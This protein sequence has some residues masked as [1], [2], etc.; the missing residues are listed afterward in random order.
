[1]RSIRHRTSSQSNTQAASTPATAGR[2]RASQ[3]P[4]KANTKR[5]WPSDTE[6]TPLLKPTTPTGVYRLLKEPSPSCGNSHREIKSSRLQA[7]PCI[8]K[9]TQAASPGLHYS[10][11]SIA[12]PLQQEPHK[13]GSAAGSVRSCRSRVPVQQAC[14]CAQHPASHIITIK[15]TGSI[16]TST[17]WVKSRVSA[18]N[19]SKR[20][21]HLA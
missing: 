11:P 16:S 5:T 12:Q 20:Q 10:I 1:M 19:K 6:D 4:T 18:A 17:G 7:H 9:Q 14:A 15:H 8:S 3:P 13:Y 21:T 2:N